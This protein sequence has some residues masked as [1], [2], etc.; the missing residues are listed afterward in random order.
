MKTHVRYFVSQRFGKST[1]TVSL[2]DDATGAVAIAL[3]CP[4]RN[5]VTFSFDQERVAQM[6][7]EPVLCPERLMR[8]A[9]GQAHKQFLLKGA[10]GLFGTTVPL[11]VG[12]APWIGDLTEAPYGGV[13]GGYASTPQAD[14]QCA[15]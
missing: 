8:I 14:T 11:V 1:V 9:I 6:L 12:S 5:R 15:S 13:T 7:G 2:S 3:P 10:S 4:E